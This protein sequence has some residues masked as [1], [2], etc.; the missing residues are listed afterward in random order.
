MERC[1]PSGPQKHLTKDSDRLYNH[2]N[3]LTMIK[4]IFMDPA[5][6][7]RKKTPNKQIMTLVDNKLLEN[8]C[9]GGYWGLEIRIFSLEHR[10]ITQNMYDPIKEPEFTIWEN[11]WTKVLLLL[12]ISHIPKSK[13]A[14]NT[15]VEI[16]HG[17]ELSQI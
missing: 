8:A 3:L 9:V 10:I 11:K 6:W 1:A 4:K 15:Y 17:C 7:L 5:S 13:N 12:C 16:L 14:L 2:S